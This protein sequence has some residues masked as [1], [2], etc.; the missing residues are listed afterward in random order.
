MNKKVRE[1]VIDTPYIK[2]GAL[3][4]F[5]QIIDN[6]GDAKSYLLDH[7]IKVNKINENRRGRKLYPNDEIEIDDEIILIKNVC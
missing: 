2:L 4:K 3:L 5:A 7:I 1:I 6:G